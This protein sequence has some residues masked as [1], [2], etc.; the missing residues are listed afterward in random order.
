MSAITEVWE[1]PAAVEDYN[2]VLLEG[3]RGDWAAE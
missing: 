2:D 1:G 3:R